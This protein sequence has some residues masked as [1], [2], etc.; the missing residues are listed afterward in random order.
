ML[1]VRFPTPE[2]AGPARR[3]RRRPRA[4][5]RFG[6]FE[7]FLL[8]SAKMAVPQ[9]AVDWGFLHHSAAPLSV[10]GIANVT[11]E[12]AEPS[13]EARALHT[14]LSP[15]VAVRSRAQPPWGFIQYRCSEHKAFA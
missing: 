9:C 11:W 3:R 1:D 6:A 14:A 10:V 7:T 8:G 4:A 12:F 15:E 5:P 2:A 13:D